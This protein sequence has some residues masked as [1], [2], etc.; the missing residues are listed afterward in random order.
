MMVKRLIGVGYSLTFERQYRVVGWSD[1]GEVCGSGL[2]DRYHGLVVCS[3]E[4]R[5]SKL[6]ADQTLLG[7]IGVDTDKWKPSCNQESQDVLRVITVKLLHLSKGH[8]DLLRAVA[9]LVTEGR[10][11][12]PADTR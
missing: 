1:G 8:D 12:N 6:R 9:Q 10:K 3:D 5:L 4:A 7:R 11:N 2:H